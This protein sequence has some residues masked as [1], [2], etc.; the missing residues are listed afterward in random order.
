MSLSHRALFLTPTLT[1]TLLCLV[2][3]ALLVINAQDAALAELAPRY[4]GARLGITHIHPNQNDDVVAVKSCRPTLQA[5]GRRCTHDF[6]SK[7]L[8]RSAKRRQRRI[9]HKHASQIFESS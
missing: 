5:D 2:I 8:E 6:R 1:L 9:V 7:R 3:N 4:D